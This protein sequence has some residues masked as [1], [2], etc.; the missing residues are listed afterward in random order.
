M[1]LKEVYE[2]IADEFD[3]TRGYVWKCVKEFLNDLSPKSK[4]LEVGCGNGKNMLYRN[5]LDFY[6]IDFCEKF[7]DICHKKNLKVK[8]GDILNIPYNENTFDS[9]ISIAV[10]HHLDTK[11]KRLKGIEELIR[12]TKKDGLIF[13]L[14]WAKEQPEKSKRK[15]NS[16]DEMVPWI[17]RSDGKTVYRYYHVYD[18]YELL[19][20]VSQ[21]KVDIIKY[22]YEFGNI[23]IIFK[24]K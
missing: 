21:F 4:V 13:I 20:D 23:G 8:F 7:I 16:N 11:E 5:D 12:V 14:V 18:N 3:H 22:F 24:K 1:S 2:E 6:G 15:F 10:V 9:T 17:K 19:D